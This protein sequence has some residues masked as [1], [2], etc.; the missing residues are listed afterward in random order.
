MNDSEIIDSAMERSAQFA[1]QVEQEHRLAFASQMR[2]K[3]GVDE[4][5]LNEPYLPF[6]LV[7]AELRYLRRMTK[8]EQRMQASKAMPFHSDC[9]IEYKADDAPVSAQI[10][11]EENRAAIEAK[12]DLDSA[13][14]Q[15]FGVN[16]YMWVG[17][18][19][20]LC[21]PNDGQ[22]FSWGEGDEPG[23][24][25]PNCGCSAE[26]VLEGAGD[27]NPPKISAEDIANAALLLASLI[28][29]VRAGRIGV[30]AVRGLGSV[31]RRILERVGRNE[32][33]TPPNQQPKPQ[34]KPPENSPAGKEPPPGGRTNTKWELGRHKSDTKWENQM[35]KR[36]WDKEKITDTIKNGKEY[37][38][39]NKVNP[40]N[41]ATRYEYNG[42]SVVRDDK[43]N[44]IL[45]VGGD[46][47]GY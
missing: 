5:L 16:Q 47:F 31:G 3:L 41:T 45:Q 23:S 2:E 27:A 40:E 46:G 35:E 12:Q 14:Q 8:I 32:E 6:L 38:A 29:A 1:A 15:A 21:A 33:P 37:P 42:R 10:A 28:P 36:G 30:A 24:V 4:I 17:G 11:A 20:P 7:R 34:E 25:H 22:I 26:P 18:D 44:E 13:R 39:P 9:C 19:C 43:T